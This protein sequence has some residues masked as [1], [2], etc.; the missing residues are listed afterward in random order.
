MERRLGRGLEALIPE[1]VNK[2]KEK[3]EVVKITDIMPNQKQPRRV[4]NEEKLKELSES[5]KQKGIIQPILTRIKEGKYEIIAGERRWRA[6]KALGLEEIPV[7]VRRDV[8]DV[9]SLELAL[10][11]NIQREELNPIEEARAYKELVEKYEYTLEKAGEVVGKGKTT[12]ANSL[13]LLNLSKPMQDSVEKG[14]L[15]TGHAKVLLAV[16]SEY[17]RENLAKKVI[18][19]NLSVRQLEQLIR[20]LDEVKSKPRKHKDPEVAKIE[21]DLQHKF[22]T[23]VQVH[24]GKKR[25]S[26]EIQY[27]SL[28]DLNRILK[29]LIPEALM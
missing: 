19:K 24:Y 13:R 25:G 3:I 16:P 12:V 21:E 28:D 5:I 23:K 7:I 17:R 26:I 29:M 2:S 27:F 18:E 11:E 14:E 20:F 4:F 22:K 6:A 8:N 9:T 1:S 10:I 15:T